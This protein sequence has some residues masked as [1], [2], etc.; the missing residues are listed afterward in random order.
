MAVSSDVD[1]GASGMAQDANS[2]AAGSASNRR[3]TMEGGG[4]VFMRVIIG[5]SRA[6]RCGCRNRQAP[7]DVPETSKQGPDVPKLGK[8]HNVEH[9]PQIWRATRATRSLLE[10][11]DP[12]DRGHM[13][14]APLPERIFEIDEF[15]RHLVEFPMLARTAIDFQPRGFHARVMRGR[16]RP[17]AFKSFRRNRETS[18]REQADDFIVERG[19]VERRFHFREYLRP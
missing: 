2:N 1:F 17:V 3:R 13:P 6:T 16:L 14:K 7:F 18:A 11:D 19:S 12:L 10:S 5:E 4:S 9:L 8:Q 15:F